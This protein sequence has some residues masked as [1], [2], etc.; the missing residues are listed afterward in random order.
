MTRRADKDGVL[1]AN[2]FITLE[3]TQIYTPDDGL[4]K[5]SRAQLDVIVSDRLNFY[6]DAYYLDQKGMFRYIANGVNYETARHDKFNVSYRYQGEDNWQF[7]RTNA[8][9]GL[10]QVVALTYMNYI[11]I[12]EQKFVDHGGGVALTPLSECWNLRFEVINH[13][14]PQDIR[15]NVW[16]NLKGLGSAGN[17]K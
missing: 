2:D 5:I 9:V 4:F 10:T 14:D 1:R 12:T 6:S 7:V 11:N 13:T 15:Y 16:I 17:R 3:L 8:Q